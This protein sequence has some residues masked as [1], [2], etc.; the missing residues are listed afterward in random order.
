[1]FRR[2]IAFR[3]QCVRDMTKLYS[4]PA[5]C[6]NYGTFGRSSTRIP[7]TISSAFGCSLHCLLSGK[8]FAHTVWYSGKLEGLRK[9]T[10]AASS[11]R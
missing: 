7:N 3:L 8:L 1:M 2:E 6:R 4:G 5:A 11:A 10:E 9:L